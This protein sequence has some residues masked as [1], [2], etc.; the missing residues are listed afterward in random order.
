M[1]RAS[2]KRAKEAPDVND[3]AVNTAVRINKLLTEDDRNVWQ[4]LEALIGVEADITTG[5]KSITVALE[6]LSARALELRKKFPNKSAQ[7]R[8]ALS[9][10]LVEHEYP[11][12][13]TQVVLVA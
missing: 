6:K 5:R 1:R 11:P 3:V 12:E 13:P 8:E 9:V 2:P 4:S 10:I 7:E